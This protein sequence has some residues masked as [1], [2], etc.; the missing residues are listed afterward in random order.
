M[1][2]QFEQ[3][4]ME[5]IPSHIFLGLSLSTQPIHI[6]SIFLV[7]H[8]MPFTIIFYEVRKIAI[9]IFERARAEAQI[10][11]ALRAGFVAL[12]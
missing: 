11:F 1:V 2:Q 4:T 6:V 9:N 8:N 3:V 12:R 7:R 10:F 5:Q